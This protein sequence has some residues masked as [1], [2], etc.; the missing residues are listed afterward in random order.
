MTSYEHFQP[1][2]AISALAG[3]GKTYQLASRYIALLAMEFRPES[4]Q[5]ITFT[6][7]A[8]GEIFDRVVRRLAEAAASEKKREELERDIRVQLGQSADRGISIATTDAQTWLKTMI[9]AMPKLR[10]G[11]IDSLFVSILRAYAVELGLP[12]RQEMLEGPRLELAQEEALAQAYRAVSGDVTAHAALLHAFKLATSEEGKSIGR[13]M[14]DVI[15]KGYDLYLDHPNENSWGAKDFMWPGGHAGWSQTPEDHPM[16]CERIRCLEGGYLKREEL[17]AGYVKAWKKILDA[18][19]ARDWDGAMENALP[20]TLFR[21]CQN[22]DRGSLQLSFGTREYPLSGD[23]AEHARHIANAII[24]GAIEGLLAEAQGMH[25]L[26]NAYDR[27]Y[28]D[29]LRHRG[30]LS[31][32]D[33][34]LLL[35]RLCE[36]GKKLDIEY[37][38]DGQIDHW[39]VDEFQD[40]SIRQWDVI[41]G[42]A[43]EVLSSQQSRSFFYVGDVKQAIYAWRGGKSTLFEHVRAKYEEA[44]K[45]ENLTTSWRSSPVVLDAVNTAFGNIDHVTCLGEYALTTGN[46]K[47]HWK[48]HRVADR[49]KD[50]PGRVELHE[51]TK[52]DQP[53][54]RIH[55]TCKIVKELVGQ[56][57]KSI[58]VLVRQ[59]NFGNRVA[60]A[61]R[62]ADVP[63]RREANPKL[64][65]NAVVSALLSML[66]LAE[67]PGDLFA[68]RHVQNSPLWNILKGWADIAPGD[69]A[70]KQLATKVREAAGREGIAGML[71]QIVGACRSK[72]VAS[73][74]FI[75]TRM[76]QLL[77]AAAEFDRSGDGGLDDFARLASSLEVRD[78]GVQGQVVV[79]TI[80]KAKGLEFDAVVLPELQG[81]KLQ[82]SNPD[83]G[84]LKVGRTTDGDLENPWV[85][86]IPK[87][88]LACGDPLLENFTHDVM[89]HGVSE[90]LCLLYVAM[91]RARQGLYMVMDEPPQNGKAIY[92]STFLGEV[93]PRNIP[94]PIPEDSPA[95]NPEMEEKTGKKK[96]KSKKDKETEAPTYQ[97]PRMLYDAGDAEWPKKTE[98]AKPAE[99]IIPRIEPKAFRPE[100]APSRPAHVRLKYMT[101]SGEE[102][103]DVQRPAQL[104]FLAGKRDAAE[105]GILLHDLF[106]RIEWFT[107]DAGTQALAGHEKDNGSCP[108]AVR[109]EFEKALASEAVQ[110]ALKRPSQ[111]AESWREQAFEFAG[112]DAWI[113]G[114]MDRVVVER[115]PAGQPVAATVVDFKSDRVKSDAEIEAMKARYE[116][117]ISRYR[118]VLSSLL[119][120]PE[121]QIRAQLILTRTGQVVEYP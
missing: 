32:S 52:E 36:P 24:R 60:D 2:K 40:T 19:K 43:N 7:A 101:P 66:T 87:E 108:E 30:R 1:F 100:A 77:D 76:S 97:L 74:P 72:G 39:L 34:P 85:F 96:G 62:K 110:S 120:L 46:W 82:W 84:K 80:H 41:K 116:P 89:D 8:A 3:S 38:L 61:L 70:I 22:Q 53:V 20:K 118:Q 86:P 69:H 79:M 57:V 56:G 12:S 10:I 13:V 17:Q 78:P 94:S 121:N 15:E 73:D 98:E 111:S 106:S 21:A 119:G 59:N 95:N 64:M 45:L 115:G 83:T 63:V 18:V 105:R 25:H 9:E 68:A 75:A 71:E 51:V 14:L 37:R 33:V 55:H 92:A 28:Q 11:T 88:T 35:G 91:T 29:E 58:G 16:I 114:R 113:S 117:Q 5:A 31:F 26:L 6:R 103:S 27:S 47:K 109:E 90:E 23:D 104:L 50:L 48:E 49:N 112:T 93:L 54:P 4:I 65:D 67:H 107:G 102:R 42:L 81:S 99:V 44:F